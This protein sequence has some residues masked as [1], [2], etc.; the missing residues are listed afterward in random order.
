MATVGVRG[1]NTLFGLIHSISISMEA[2]HSKLVSTNV[3]GCITWTVWECYQRRRSESTAASGETHSQ[4]HRRRSVPSNCDSE[5]SS[6]AQSV[7]SSSNHYK[8]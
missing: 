2:N 5:V 1:L 8:Q 3:I 6:P 4:E 7:D